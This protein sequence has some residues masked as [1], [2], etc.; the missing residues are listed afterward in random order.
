MTKVDLNKK[1]DLHKSKV[2]KLRVDAKWKTP[3][4]LKAEVDLNLSALVCKSLEKDGITET[5]LVNED[6]FIFYGSKISPDKAICLLGNDD[7]SGD[8]RSGKDDTDS[9]ILANLDKIEAL[10]ATDVIFL[11]SI[12]DAVEKEQ[13]FGLLRE[14][15]V[16]VL[17]NDTDE[18]ILCFPF[19][20]GEFNEETI[21][22]IGTAYVSQVAENN[23]KKV[24]DFQGFGNGSPN[25]DMSQILTCFGAEVSD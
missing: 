19:G 15:F 4:G 23:N 10:E 6:Y 20:K 2:K 21:I 25:A 18:E 3:P 7:R 24:W 14:G 22:H 1:Q 13:N 9:T 16:R 5:V 17:D 8:G 11:L 12:Y